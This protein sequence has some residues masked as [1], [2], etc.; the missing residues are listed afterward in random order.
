MHAIFAYSRMYWLMNQLQKSFQS[1]FH[2]DDLKYLQLFTL[3]HNKNQ[4][5]KAFF[6]FIS[7][8]ISTK[9][10]NFTSVFHIS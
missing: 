8:E 7:S 4:F 10:R 1:V 5:G 3:L 9:I 2:S 6:G